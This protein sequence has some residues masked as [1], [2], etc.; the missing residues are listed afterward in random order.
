MFP[1][2]TDETSSAR[3]GLVACVV[4]ALFAALFVF[5]ATR[6]ASAGGDDKSA[7]AQDYTALVTKS[8]DFRFGQN[9]FAPSNASSTTGTLIPGSK[10]PP[11]APCANGD[12]D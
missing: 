5:A 12:G 1:T 8:Y 11:P 9:P 3:R 4:A 10:F 2:E 6:G 7:A